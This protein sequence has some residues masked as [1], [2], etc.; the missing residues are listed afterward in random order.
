MLFHPRLKTLPASQGVTETR[1]RVCIGLE[2]RT[3][4]LPVQRIYLVSD[5][6]AC[7]SCLIKAFPALSQRNDG[8]GVRR[9]GD[10]WSNCV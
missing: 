2:N 4:K 1:V 8:I 7:F 10:H 5:F 9:R 6:A 3:D